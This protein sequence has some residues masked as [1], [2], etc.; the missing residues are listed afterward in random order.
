MSGAAGGSPPGGRG[1]RAR[2]APAAYQQA[3]RL[4]VRR[5]HS[6]AELRRRLG[7][8]G[9]AADELDTALETLQRQGF[10]D[11][12]R[13][14][15]ALLRSRAAA[16]RGPLRIR[17]ELRQNG[18]AA[19]HIEAAFAAAAAEGLDWQALAARVAARF[20]PGLRRARGPDAR[21]ERQRALAFLLRR[22]FPQA[23]A[24]QALALPPGEGVDADEWM[25]EDAGGLPE[26][27]A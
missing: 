22:G 18:V 13:Y 11:D 20:I 16:G 3:L 15:G 19:G 12:A 7:G 2:P 6:A 27:G 8:R 5:E 26:D 24:R 4:L 17:A 25:A 9:L 23:L 14:A 21:R 1:R 10:Q